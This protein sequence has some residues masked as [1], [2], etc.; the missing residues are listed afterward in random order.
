[1]TKKTYLR[2]R[3]RAEKLNMFLGL[4]KKLKWMDLLDINESDWNDKWNS[5]FIKKIK[6]KK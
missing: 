3:D 1:M 6:I 5:F 2:D 4:D